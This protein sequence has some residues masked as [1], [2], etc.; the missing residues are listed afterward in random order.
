MADDVYRPKKS[1]EDGD[2][3]NPQAS[4]SPTEGGDPLANVKAMQDAAQADRDVADGAEA[5]KPTPLQQNPDMPFQVSGNVPPAFQQAVQQKQRSTNTP[6]ESSSQSPQHSQMD[7]MRTQRAVPPIPDRT[8]NLR[9]QGSEALE[10]LL[11][12]LSSNHVWE[13]I[14]LPSKGKFYE[15]LDATVNLRPMTGEEEQILATPRFI[16]KGQAID[17]IFQR[18]IRENVDT[19]ELLSIDRT[20]ILIYLRGISYTPEYDV[21]IKCSSCDTKFNTVIDLNS[22]EVESCPETFDEKSLKGVLPT[23]GFDYKFKLATGGDEQAV[24]NYREKRIRMFGDQSEDDT[25][26][27]RTA[28]LLEHVERVSDTKELVMLLKRLPI[29]DVSHLRNQ[30]NEPPF[31]V[32]TDVGLVC[33]SCMEEFTVDLPLEAN[34]F[35]PRKKKEETQA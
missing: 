18:C 19:E 26:L 14:E 22:L 24:S 32:N 30:I 23:S 33:P 10:D 25:L 20:F 2:A 21:E 7:D 34:F 16:R 11:Q 31:G 4:T 5:S 1:N 29:S 17:M 3:K 6:N 35:F 8:S 12:Q 15:N 27:Y 9:I 28:V 13:E